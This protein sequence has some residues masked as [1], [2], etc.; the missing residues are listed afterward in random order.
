MGALLSLLL[1]LA[2][3]LLLPPR[4]TVNAAPP[5]Q[6]SPLSPLAPANASDTITTTD[7]LTSTIMT[8]SEVAPTAAITEAAPSVPDDIAV[9]MRSP[10][11]VTSEIERPPAVTRQPLLTGLWSLP[12]Q[13]A[14]GQIS[15]ILVAALFVGIFTVIGLV[16]RRG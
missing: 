1:A 9:E 8:A 13:L 14:S 16:L 7:L 3:T 4:S 10:L 15:L 6:S 12:E 11:T 2:G 5:V